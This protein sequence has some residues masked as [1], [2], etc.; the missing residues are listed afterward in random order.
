[1]GAWEVSGHPEGLGAREVSAHPARQAA[2][3]ICSSAVEV[4]EAGAEAMV[5]AEMVAV[6]MAAVVYKVC[7]KGNSHTCFLNQVI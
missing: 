3:D 2:A 5:A 7:R 4:L 6:E 1:M